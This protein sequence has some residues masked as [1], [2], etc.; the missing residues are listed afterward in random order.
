MD[1]RE[2]L[3]TTRAM[4]RVKSDP[5][6]DDVQQRIMDAA[7][8]A[9]SGGNTQGWRF[10]L[11]DD[12]EVIAR[13]APLYRECVDFLWAH[14][15]KDRLDAAE[16]EPDLPES[17]TMMAIHRSVEWAANNF[18]RYPLL[19]FG[20]T[21]GLDDGGSIFPAIWS[22]MLAARAEGVGSSLTSILMVKGAEVMEIL[23]VPTD[24]G[25]RM[26]CCVPMGYPTGRWGIAER[27]PAHGV[28]FKNAWGQATGWE[29]TEPLWRPA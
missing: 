4:R 5:V 27:N 1:L 12:P 24:E 13:I 19:L 2:A 6:P 26:A 7:V 9:P 18:S 16:A 20:F 29:I 25:W 15:Y 14:I 10:L 21:S 17:R 8:R 3:Y 28:T 11:V 23:G 22:A